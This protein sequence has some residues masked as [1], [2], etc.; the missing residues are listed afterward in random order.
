METLGLGIVE[1]LGLGI[2][3]T[4][5]LGIVETLGLGIVE[6]L[7]LGI[8]ETLVLCIVDTVGLESLGCAVSSHFLRLCRQKGILALFSEN[9]ELD[10]NFFLYHGERAG[11]CFK[12]RT[13]LA[14]TRS[15]IK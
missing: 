4:L 11:N 15:T 5:V 7:G 3:E 8:V 12:K 2:V 13:L 9:F 10:K 14:T 1:T 6:T